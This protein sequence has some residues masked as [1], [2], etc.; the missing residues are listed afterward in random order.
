MVEVPFFRPHETSL[1]LAWKHI[2]DVLEQS[3]GDQFVV[4]PIGLCYIDTICDF[5][6]NIFG[7]ANA[8]AAQLLPVVGR[9]DF[10]PHF[11]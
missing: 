2:F 5:L 4:D 7:E 8:S 6:N 1:P 10:P 11:V 3:D 9:R